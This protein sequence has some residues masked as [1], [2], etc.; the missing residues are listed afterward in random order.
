MPPP[1][2]PCAWDGPIAEDGS[3]FLAQVDN[4][5]RR[6][7]NP[8]CSNVRSSAHCLALLLVRW[9][10]KMCVCVCVCVWWLATY[11]HAVVMC[12]EHIS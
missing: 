12:D 2:E 9:L 7:S 6:S 11:S 5:F 10:G 1:S 8:Y 3:P 4:L